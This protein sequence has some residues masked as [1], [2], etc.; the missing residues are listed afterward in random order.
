MPEFRLRRS[1]SG[2]FV[3]QIKVIRH[4]CMPSGHDFEEWQTEHWRPAT[5]E[6]AQ[7]CGLPDHIIEC[8]RDT[9]W[10]KPAPESDGDMLA[11]IG[12]DGQKW[13]WEFLSRDFDPDDIDEGLLTGWFANAIEAG[14]TAGQE[15]LAGVLRDYILS[16]KG[17]KV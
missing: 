4:Y 17:P 13:A 2:K 1:W 6:E 10:H 16:F 7:K 9:S 5:L 3:L 12:T 15:A 8:T 14:R 11:R